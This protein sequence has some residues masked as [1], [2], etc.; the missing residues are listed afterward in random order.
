M[1]GLEGNRSTVD[2]ERVVPIF[3]G[4]PTPAEEEDVSVEDDIGSRLDE[5]WKVILFN[6]DIHTFDEVIVQLQKATGCSLQRAENIAFEAHTRGKAVAYNGNFQE[7]FKV[8]S[9]LREIQLLVEIE[10]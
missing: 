4:I 2:A 10:G 1:R 3:M 7:C 6:D 9:V 8:A 5:P